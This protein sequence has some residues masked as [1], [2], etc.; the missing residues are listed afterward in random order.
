MDSI[1]DVVKISKELFD[2]GL[3]TGKAGNISIRYDKD[4]PT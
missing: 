2:K 1:K 4:A 3:V